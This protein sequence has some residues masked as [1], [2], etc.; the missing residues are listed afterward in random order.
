MEEGTPGPADDLLL[1]HVLEFLHGR[2][3]PGDAHARLAI[4]AAHEEKLARS[5]RILRHPSAAPI[6]APMK[7]TRAERRPVA[8]GTQL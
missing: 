5:N 6:T 4:G 3:V 1:E 2:G 7:S 8:P